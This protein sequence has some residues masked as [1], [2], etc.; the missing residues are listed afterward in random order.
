M[1][2]EKASTCAVIT[3]LSVGSQDTFVV[4]RWKPGYMNFHWRYDERVIQI[5]AGAAVRAVH[6]HGDRTVVVH[7]GRVDV[8]GPDNDRGVLRRVE[9]RGGKPICAVSRDA[10]LAFACAGAEVGEAHV[11]RWLG[12]GES[13]P[14]SFAAHSSRLECVAMSWDGRLV[15]TASFK[16]TIVRVFHAAD[17]KLLH[18]VRSSSSVAESR[19]L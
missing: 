8:Y 1:L 9:T 10:P 4:R 5:D 12:D 17:G 7:D 16:G 11:E 19:W 15:A 14:L 6:V 18:E 2:D 3:Q 13:A